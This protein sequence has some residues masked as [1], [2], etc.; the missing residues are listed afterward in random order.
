MRVAHTNAAKYTLRAYPKSNPLFKTQVLMLNFHFKHIL[1]S[2]AQG[3]P[4]RGAACLATNRPNQLQRTTLKYGFREPL[5]WAPV[6][7]NFIQHNKHI[8]YTIYAN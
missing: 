1:V 2:L 8:S 5:Q 7:L 4:L 3:S 6:L